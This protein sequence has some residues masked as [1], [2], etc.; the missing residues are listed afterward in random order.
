MPASTT[1]DHSSAPD[2]EPRDSTAPA[3][4]SVVGIGAS[5]GGLDALERLFRN[6]PLDTGA[7]F[8]VVQHLSPDHKSMMAQLLARHT[9]M[10]VVLVEDAMDLTADQIHLIPP[11]ALLTVADGRLHLAPKN[12]HL[13]SLPIDLFLAS[14]AKSYGNRAIGVILSG[15]G[16]DGTRGGV[17]IND[18]GG[19][20]LAQDPESARFDGMPRSVIATGRVDDVLPPET[21]GPRIAA[22]LHRIPGTPRESRPAAAPESAPPGAPL[23]EILIL[24]QQLAGVNFHDYKPDTLLRRIERRAHVRRVPDLQS[25]LRLLEGDPAEVVTLRRDLLIPVTRFF[26]DNEAFGQL[27]STLR[28]WIQTQP[29]R[30]EP[31]RVWV[32]GTSTGEEAYSIAMILHEVFAEMGRWPGF[33]IFAT[34]V[35]QQNIDAASAGLYSDAVVAEIGSERIERF[36]VKREN[37]F[38]IRSDLR[39]NI[40]FARHNLLEDA[41]FT[42]MDLVTCRNLL[43]YLKPS[44][45]ERALRRLQYALT[46]GGILFLGSSESLGAL[47]SEFSTLST[48]NKLYRVLRPA[49]LPDTRTSLTPMRGSGARKRPPLTPDSIAID[50]AQN[51]LLKDYAPPALLVNTG[52]DLIH[53][54][55]DVQRFLTFPQGTASLDLIRLL[56]KSF[57][58]IAMAILHKATREGRLVR[59]EPMPMPDQGCLVRLTAQPVTGPET[60]EATLLLA[61]E[62]TAAPVAT[63]AGAELDLGAET[64]ERIATLERELGATRESLQTAI[65]ELETTNQELQATNEELMASNEEL[66]S[67]NEELQSVNEELYTVNAEN[68]ERIEILNRLNADL[69]SMSKASGLAT[70]FVDEALR[71]TRFTP[72]ARQVFS[73]REGDL[74]RPLDDFRHHLE[75]PDFLGEIRRTIE[76]NEPFEQEITADNGRLYLTRIFPYKMPSLDLAGAMA[77]FTDVTELDETT[78]ARAVVN[79]LPGS[80]AMLDRSGR[81]TAVNPAWRAR[82]A[83][84]SDPELPGVGADLRALCRN[85]GDAAIAETL[86]RGVTA[87]LTGE[88]STFEQD[89]A[90]DNTQQSRVTRLL[91]FAIRGANGGGVLMQI[92]PTQPTTSMRDGVHPER[93]SR[94]TRT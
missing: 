91:A 3:D 72:E 70:L 10:P 58:A 54:F 13:L 47:Q 36:F 14:L 57:A 86:E 1:P 16:S 19:L 30:T 41:P 18:A 56:P 44:A 55:G 34:D 63:A 22:H 4:G 67:S 25:Y 62:E 61:F 26:R 24:L 76:R 28:D 2:L 9:R 92:D 81:I 87:V 69:D 27:A 84:D 39:Q 85:L 83:G 20:L 38:M 48:R 5:A 33:K 75:H 90:I 71:L 46:P 74:G 51:R 53:I 73:I 80:V 49:R 89:C 8:V 77:T 66:Q 82:A 17:A 45:Q 15:T 23:E 37:H 29:E 64:A 59:S 88:R 68:Q 35:E 42:R 94:R 7:A 78:Q 52:H 65:E 21:L 50:T 32:A 12:P 40:V 79:T 60:G 43:I 6:M 93:S 11:G 31:L